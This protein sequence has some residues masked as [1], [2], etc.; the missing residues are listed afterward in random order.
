MRGVLILIAEND[1]TLKVRK[2]YKKCLKKTRTLMFVIIIAIRRVAVRLC[3]VSFPPLSWKTF[4]YN[5]VTLFADEWCTRRAKWAWSLISCH[6]GATGRANCQPPLPDIS[7]GD[8]VLS[9]GRA[10]GQII[11]FSKHPVPFFVVFFFHGRVQDA[12]GRPVSSYKRQQYSRAS[13]GLAIPRS[14]RSFAA[15]GHPKARL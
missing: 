14:W 8:H 1:T 13:T 9:W 2:T 11:Y 12:N 5:L 6:A 10:R 4:D 7:G 15:H 3:V